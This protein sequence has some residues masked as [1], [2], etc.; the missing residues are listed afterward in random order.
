MTSPP[1]KCA[2]QKWKEAYNG[3]NATLRLPMGKPSPAG[4]LTLLSLSSVGFIISPASAWP[5]KPIFARSPGGDY[6]ANKG[7]WIHIV[8]SRKE[9]TITSQGGTPQRTTNPTARRRDDDHIFISPWEQKKVAPP[10]VVSVHVRGQEE[11]ERITSCHLHLMNHRRL[12][13]CRRI[14]SFACYKAPRSTFT[15]PVP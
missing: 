15:L 11:Q 12:S 14:V 7:V 3:Q 6:A 1:V 13:Q 9:T 8:F 2:S 4:R 5:S 10:M